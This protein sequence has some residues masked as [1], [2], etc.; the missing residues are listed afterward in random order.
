MF[1]V[2]FYYHVSHYSS[3]PFVCPLF[4]HDGILN[5]YRLSLLHSNIAYTSE[6]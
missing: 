1:I 2:V 3:S 5:N 6:V 4:C